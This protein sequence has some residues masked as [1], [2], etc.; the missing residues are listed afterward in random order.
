M[1]EFKAGDRVRVKPHVA[2]SGGKEVRVAKRLTDGTFVFPGPDADKW[3][4]PSELE[5]VE[6]HVE[7][8][9]IPENIVFVNPR[10]E[11]IRSRTLRDAEAL[12]NGDRQDT[13]GT[14]TESLGR[15][16]GLWSVVLG[17]EIEPAQVALLLASLKVARLSVGLDHRDGWVDLAGYAAIGAEVADAK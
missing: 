9:D 3:F 8:A 11:N 17:Q 6:Q 14:P 15:I 1:S 4:Y 13:Y 7:P 12:V 5:L 10:T 2:R 16:A